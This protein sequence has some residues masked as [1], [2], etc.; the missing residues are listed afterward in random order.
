MG[1]RPWL[2]TTLGLAVSA[3]ASCGEE[4]T[5]PNP[6]GEQKVAGPELAVA[7]NTWITRRDMWGIDRTAFATATVP[8]AAG[9]SV[10]YVI[11]GHGASGVGL[12]SVMAYNVAT[13]TWTLRAP[14]PFP[15][16]GTNVAAVINGKIYITGG[17][18]YGWPVGAML[19]YDPAKN[20][21]VRKSSMPSIYPPDVDYHLQ[22]GGAT[23]TGAINGKLYVLTECWAIDYEYNDCGLF[24]LMFRYNPVTDR[25]IRLASPPPDASWGFVVWPE[26]GGM[27]GVISG[28]LYVVGSSGNEGR[29]AVYDPATNQWAAKRG[30]GQ[31]RYGAASVVHAGKLYLIGGIRFNADE[32][33]EVLRA[34]IAYDPTTDRWTNYAPMPTARTGL[35]GS[36]V[37]LNG[38][39]RLE[40]IGGS[41]PG[42]NLQY[43]P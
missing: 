20:T 39:P 21:W 34:N 18:S 14:L 27:G 16:Y 25:W 15:L 13:N 23:L 32:T 17:Y 31:P 12:T 26:V 37:T 4:T 19:M 28:K 40:V 2:Y 41:R 42:N 6:A 11:G 35:G 36:R 1:Y 30:L 10:V 29:L 43:V 33:R 5:E 9:Q 24:H 8:N 7:S 22:G 38:Q 3:L